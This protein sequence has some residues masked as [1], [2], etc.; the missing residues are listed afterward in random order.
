VTRGILDVSLLMRQLKHGSFICNAFNCLNEENKRFSNSLFLS[1]YLIFFSS[2]L[3]L[4]FFFFSSCF[5]P[6]IAI[7][8]VLDVSLLVR[9][10]KGFIC[11]ASCF[12]NWPGAPS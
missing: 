1:L 10:L 11:N 4:C 5:M 2:S 8:D 7:R 9:Q 12:I 3:A 6:R